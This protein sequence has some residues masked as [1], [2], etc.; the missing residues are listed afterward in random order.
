MNVKGVYFSIF[1][2]LKTAL[3]VPLS[4]LL[5][6][7]K[8]KR[9]MGI[10]LACF[11]GYF[12]LINVLMTIFPTQWILI[13]I[14]NGIPMYP[15]YNVFLYGLTA[16]FSNKERR[17]TAFGIFN[18]IGTFGYI[19]GI[20]IVGVI[21]DHWLTGKYAGIFSMFPMSIILTGFGFLTALFFY[22]TVLRKSENND[23]EKISSVE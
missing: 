2:I 12:V 6:R 15:I 13:L 20:I 21:A 19:T 16:S 23:E 1:I 9:I 4:F 5:G 10:I 11:T 22:I 7:V 8:R 14:I 18:A 3:A 17:A